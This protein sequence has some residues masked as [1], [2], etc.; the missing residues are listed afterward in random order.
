MRDGK[1]KRH[2]VDILFVLALF[3]LFAV[4]SILLIAVVGIYG[5]AYNAASF[6]YGGF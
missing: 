1:N 5:P 3:L 6:I 4:S 2:I